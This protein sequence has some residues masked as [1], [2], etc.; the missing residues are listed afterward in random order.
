MATE[1]EQNNIENISRGIGSIIDVLRQQA[2]DA[3]IDVDEVAEVAIDKIISTPAQ[4]VQ[5]L[6]IQPL[7][8]ATPI[9]AGV[10]DT[11]A[12]AFQQAVNI[13]QQQAA[14]QIA[15]NRDASAMMSAET[16]SA[17]IN[18]LI[19]AVSIANNRNFQAISQTNV[20]VPEIKSAVVSIENAVIP[21]SQS[22]TPPAVQN[23]T[24]VDGSAI[25]NTRSSIANTNSAIT[26]NNSLALR[27][28]GSNIT[29]NRN[30]T[31]LA[32]SRTTGA[33]AS[34]PIVIPPAAPSRPGR[35]VPAPTSDRTRKSAPKNP[36]SGVIPQSR[37]SQQ[38]VVPNIEGIF[39]G[40]LFGVVPKSAIRAYANKIKYLV[41]EL[42]KIR[43]P[44]QDLVK[45]V[46]PLAKVSDAVSSFS[47]ISW[48]KA[49]VSIKALQF[50]TKSF[51]SSI[52]KTATPE[53]LKSLSLFERFSKKLS[54]PLTDLSDSLN[55]FANIAWAKVI[56][57]SKLFSFFLKSISKM[58]L[59]TIKAA[60][61]VFKKLANSLKGPLE[62]LGDTL[63]KF[64]NSLSKFAGSLIK[65]AVAIALLGA[66]LVPLAYGL[67]MFADVDVASILKATLALGGLVVLANTLKGSVGTM[68]KGAGAIAILGASLIPLSI[69]LKTMDG[70]GIDTIGILA[71]SLATL[72]IASQSLG[73]SAAQ[74]LKGAGAIAVLGASLIPLSIGL[75][76]MENVG[77]ETIGVVAAALMTLGIAGAALGSAVS[78][79]LKGAGAIAV[80]GAAI[81][82]LAF[83]LKLMESV[84]M[85]TIGVLATALITLAAASAALGL[86]LPYIL[87]GAL[88][89]AVLGA[90]IIPLAFGLKMLSEADPEKLTALIVPMLGLAGAGLALL[91][92]APGLLAAGFALIPFA[93]GV[94]ALSMAIDGIDIGVLKALPKAL[95]GLSGAAWALAASAPAL[96]IAGVA[97]APFAGGIKLLSMAIDGMDVDVLNALPTALS[98]LTDAASDLAWSSI[99]LAVAGAALVPF[100]L[101]LKALNVA[102]NGMNTDILNALPTALSN[103]TD[104]ASDLAWS[105]FSLTLAGAALVPFS[106]GLK[107]LSFAIEDMD[108][109]VLNALSKALNTLATAAWNLTKASPALITAGLALI[110]F[111]AG[112]AA[113]GLAVRVGGDGLIGFI[114]KMS[115]FTSNLDPDKLYSTAGAI[116]ALSG[117]IAAFG[118]A[119]TAEGLGNLVGRF[120]RFG[121]DSPLEQMQKFAL[122][123]DQLK[124]A[125]EGVL[126]LSNGISKLSSLGGDIEVLDNF[127]WE[128][129]EDLAD[130]INGKAIIQIVTGGGLEAKGQVIESATGKSIGVPNQ[131]VNYST[132]SDEEK[133]KAAGYSSVEEYK[134][135][136]LKW[137]G[138]APETSIAPMPNIPGAELYASGGG[139]ATS[140]PI[141]I[142]NNTGG[143]VS[144]V[145]TNNVNNTTTSAPLITGSALGFY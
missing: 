125:G 112:V 38:L 100:S 129:L 114:N 8:P 44:R 21:V 106:L 20:R 10:A 51:S 12:A 41:S 105:S 47:Q 11:N 61:N 115:E 79:V 31:A 57:G 56:I 82:P 83:G 104:A 102:L 75:K 84:G 118:A 89:I 141:I 95:I 91:V 117:A 90:S 28:V 108:V 32:I 87:P 5:Q 62:S 94:K 43:V 68:I 27:N 58:P 7:T 92:G 132:L 109:G 14:E 18:P 96:L 85:G 45:I 142:N 140:A 19:N 15:A 126:N 134:N 33:A 60:S 3:I 2:K 130:A 50:F 136:E 128:E 35:N 67:K 64:G 135:S 88:A 63:E 131:A 22:V 30:S 69:G 74:V 77:I 98:N 97:L 13:V 29:N 66:S 121:A 127:P 36:A 42:G 26:N 9:T 110:P 6:D 24:N 113:L 76:T 54:E 107:A 116:V 53:N 25:T 46:D 48:G 55:E 39:K 17:I 72:A 139:G 120:L 138:T 143:N 103:L 40:L 71:T 1:N 101:G 49:F 93:L 37:K 52:K 4:L 122:I 145:S 16:L 123:G 86:A 137:K 124:S 119:Q 65:G 23:V 59:D 99:S 111:S 78:Q 80:L 81:V 144:N 133:A 70:V 34:E 73:K